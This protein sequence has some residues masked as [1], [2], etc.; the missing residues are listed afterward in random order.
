M[1]GEYGS[2]L[3]SKNLTASEQYTLIGNSS[4]Q[5][6]KGSIIWYRY[7][8]KFKQAAIWKQKT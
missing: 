3:S 8:I 5:H 6:K 2:E 7:G 4:R 1:E